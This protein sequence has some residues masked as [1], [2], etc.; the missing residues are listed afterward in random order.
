MR[1]LELIGAWLAIGMLFCILIA[2]F[3]P[4]RL[5]NVKGQLRFT[6]ASG[7]LL[8]WPLPLCL[9]SMFVVLWPIRRL[10]L[11]RVGPIRI[12]PVISDMEE[13]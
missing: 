6:Y 13:I 3:S 8:L 1:N 4:K 11:A 5:L 2:V 9:L 12:E 10:A 7:L